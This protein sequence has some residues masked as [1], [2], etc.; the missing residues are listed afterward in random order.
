MDRR[1]MVSSLA[2]L[3]LAP[4]GLR[5]AREAKPAPGVPGCNLPGEGRGDD[6]WGCLSDEEAEALRREE[7]ARF[8]Y[9]LSDV[10]YRARYGDEELA[11]LVHAEREESNQ[12]RSPAL[13]VE[14]PRHPRYG[15][16]GPPEAF[17]EV[18]EDE[19]S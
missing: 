3:A 9:D 12:D 6:R 4:F 16:P 19:I 18:S 11:K 15:Y 5:V 13:G 10:E 8:G 17:W 2:A 7:Q 14:Y 1:S